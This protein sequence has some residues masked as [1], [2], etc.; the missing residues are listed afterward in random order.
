MKEKRGVY[1]WLRRLFWL[2]S[3]AAVVSMWYYM[4]RVVPDRVSITRNKEEEFLFDLPLKT[5]ISSSSREVT[6]GNKSNIPSEQV[7][8]SG[9]QPFSM[10]GEQQGSYEVS[11]K[12]LGLIRLKNIQVDVVDTRYAIPCGST[13]GIYLKC[14]G[15][16][17]IGTGR[18][19]GEDGTE[20]DPACGYLKSG[21]Y[22]EAVNGQPMH[23]KEELVEAVGRTGGREADLQVRRD[24]SRMEVKLQPVKSAE[25]Q[26]RL[27][28][29]VR[30]DTQG[31]GT[32]TY[33][34]LNGKF[35]AL[36]H[37]IS[38]SDTGGLV[39]TKEGALYITQI[40]GIEK[41]TIGRPGLL[42]GVIY[43]GPQSRLGDIT[44]NTNEGIFGSVNGQFKKQLKGEAMAIASR[45]EVKTGPAWIRSGI[46]GE[47]K[48]YAIEIQ[49]IDYSAGRKNKSLIIRVTDPALLELTGGI[50]QGMSG[51]PIIQ[52]GKLAGAVTHVFVQDASRGYGIFVESMMEH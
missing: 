28:A 38:D 1:R 33:V 44:A 18:I 6:L 4:E 5:T 39:E 14:D 40:M 25:G 21:D 36:G 48:D 2:S 42:S 7:V 45:Q 37:G 8:I 23:T 16:M 35:G 22:I 32:M 19:T 34:D 43:Y 51:S 9:R 50:V 26:Y 20:T 15:V 12:L 11:L 52:N 47:M 41:G 13:I 30:D 29:W 17:V 3:F 24:G 10:Y 27:G 46:S 31:I 49:K